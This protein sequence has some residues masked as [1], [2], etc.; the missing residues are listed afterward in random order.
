M[1]EDKNWFFK[2]WKKDPTIKSMLIMLDTIH[3]R[4][5]NTKDNNLFD[6]LICD[7][8][9]KKA[10]TFDFLPLNDFNLSD[11]LYIKM[12]ARGKPLTH[13][14]N[15][16]SNFVELLDPLTTSKLDNEWTDLFW[17]FK[18]KSQEDGYYYI[19]DKILNFFTNCII[20]LGI[21]SNKLVEKKDLK[22]I[23]IMDV[24]K[25]ILDG[26]ENSVNLKSLISILNIL[27]GLEKDKIPN[28]FNN[29][30]LG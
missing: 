3:E 24:Y 2:S 22:E 1:I 14:E 26:E 9:D 17:S 20:N 15:F 19:D 18:G 23:D 6:K 28:Y 27:S 12:N 7:D 30:I 25:H 11:E 29:F 8:D 16:K 13:F 4:F 5:E 21:V 10:I